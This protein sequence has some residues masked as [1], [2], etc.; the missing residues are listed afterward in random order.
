[1]LSYPSIIVI[2]IDHNFI[3]NK[4]LTKLSFCS[5]SLANKLRGIDNYTLPNFMKLK[6]LKKNH[7]G[8]FFNL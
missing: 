6:Q 8:H 7:I 2:N 3:F 5:L 1:M 4:Y